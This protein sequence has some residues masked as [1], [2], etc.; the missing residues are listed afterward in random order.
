MCSLFQSPNT[1]KIYTREITLL[2]GDRGITGRNTNGD[3]L[4]VTNVY[5]MLIVQ[6]KLL[7][8]RF[9]CFESCWL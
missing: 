1:R 7:Q 9:V 6:E 5:G 8:N 3:M 2:F 4:V